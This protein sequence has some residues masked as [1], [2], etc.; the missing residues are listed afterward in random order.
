MIFE[1]AS[2]VLQSPAHYS[3]SNG[4]TTVVL[5]VDTLGYNYCLFDISHGQ[6]IGGASAQ[7]VAL[8]VYE[9]D[10]TTFAT[11]FTV[12]AGTTNT[13]ASAGQFVMSAWAPEATSTVPRITRVGVQCGG[14]R[15]RYLSVVVDPP[16]AY[17]S[18]IASTANVMCTAHLFRGADMPDTAAEM[19]VAEYT[20]V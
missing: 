19:G 8:T 14:P 9:H 7:W 10:T 15:K 13:T 3:A 1:Q 20:F 2:K 11:T 12:V 17:T 6:G 4:N 18:S 5:A 16:A